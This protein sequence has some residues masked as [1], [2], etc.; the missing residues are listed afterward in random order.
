MSMLRVFPETNAVHDEEIVAADAI[1]RRLATAGVG[2]E[3]WP[4]LPELSAKS[5]QALLEGYGEQLA[6]LK[7]AHGLKHA[8][9]VSLTADHPQRESLR[10]QF[11]A[12]H[13]HDDFEI[14][15]F[16]EGEGLFY[17]HAQKEVFGLLCQ[18]GDMI[19]IPARMLHWFDM[20]ERPYFRCLR[21]FS[22]PAGWQAHN[23]GSDIAMHYPSLNDFKGEDMT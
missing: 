9:V 2:F 19:S 6:A 5:D 17:I 15:F 1:Q 4:C 13:W 16:V 22:E 10:Q 21:L 20:G 11:L 8:D 7:A 12:E 18:R 14:R 3:S 23:S